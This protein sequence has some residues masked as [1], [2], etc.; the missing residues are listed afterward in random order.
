MVGDS[1]YRPRMDLVWIP[2]I[3][4]LVGAGG[5]V[6]AQIVAAHFTGRREVATRRALA[7][8]DDKQTLFVTLIA[9]MDDQAERLQAA[10]DARTAGTSIQM[11]D[12]E[13]DA[14]DRELRNASIKLDLIAPEVIEDKDAWFTTCDRTR[15]LLTG[16]SPVSAVGAGLETL[17]ILRWRLFNAMRTSLGTSVPL[18]TK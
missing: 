2:V 16:G 14:A 1:G 17:G 6:A 10:F 7:Y 5:A 15:R 11:A 12:A 3:S 8:R 13:L 18:P 4:G 9:A